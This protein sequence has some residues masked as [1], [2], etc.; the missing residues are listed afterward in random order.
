MRRVVR[1]EILDFRTA[2]SADI[3]G[4]LR[5]LRRINRWF[6]GIHTS[7]FLVNQAL[8]GRNPQQVSL[9]DVGSATG[10][11]PAALQKSL[12]ARN[13]QLR[14]TLLDRDNIHFGVN[15]FHVPRVQADA[16]QLPFRDATFDLVIC[17]LFAHHL[18]PDQVVAFA[19]E[20]LRVSRIALLVNDLRRSALHLAFVY[21]G[22]PLFSRI[23]RHDAPTSVL[24]SY[25]PSEMTTMLRSAGASRVEMHN[26]YLFRMGAIAWK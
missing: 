2:S 20:A 25:T 21:A 1:P 15:G 18:E 12:A 5:D 11:G 6:G 24:R 17:S 19:R 16:V 4:S 7:S 26:S 13:V 3:H 10:D 9:L 14:A 22:V 8:K 23:T